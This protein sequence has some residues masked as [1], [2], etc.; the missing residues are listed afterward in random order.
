MIPRLVCRSMACTGEYHF[1]GLVVA[2]Q[3][4]AT[5]EFDRKGARLTG[6]M[7]ENGRLIGNLSIAY[8]L[9]A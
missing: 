1:M 2:G 9:K 6:W 4:Q 8:Y 7:D 5:A 3:G